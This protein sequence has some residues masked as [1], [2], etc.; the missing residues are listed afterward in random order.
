MRIAN[1]NDD[2]NDH[3]MLMIIFKW[4]PAQ[5]T[6]STARKKLKHISAIVRERL[7]SASK[8]FGSSETEESS[9]EFRLQSCHSRRESEEEAGDN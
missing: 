7:L 1:E 5:K 2:L 9:E 3:F 8:C 4:I 6:H